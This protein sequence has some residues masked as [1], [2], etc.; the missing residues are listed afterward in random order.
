MTPHH[1]PKR[2]G[3][4]V[5]PRVKFYLIHSETGQRYPLV[6]DDITIGRT[7]GDLLFAD[8]PALS[9]QHCHLVLGE[10]GLTV[11]D[12]STASGTFIDEVKLAVN[13]PT[14]FKPGQQLRVGKQVFKLQAAGVAK[15]LS[16]ARAG[17]GGRGDWLTRILLLGCLVGGGYGLRLYLVARASS[18][19]AE[20]AAR[21]KSPFELADQEVRVVFDRYNALGAEHEAGRLTQND[22]NRRIRIELLPSLQK[23][24]TSLAVVRGGSDFER[25][26]LEVNRQMVRALT[27]QVLA[28]IETTESPSPLATRRLQQFSAELQALN[29]QSQIL[30]RVPASR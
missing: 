4:N 2:Q 16:G 22:L 14:T 17:S 28:I 9:P 26:K 8:D 12:L 27:G 6:A 18:A 19:G 30:K 24:Q 1:L 10:S 7:S 21:L 11:Q 5:F 20:R 15:R 3:M 23:L 29:V 25:R 13:K